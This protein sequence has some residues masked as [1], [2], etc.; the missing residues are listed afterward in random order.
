MPSSFDPRPSIDAHRNETELGFIFLRRIFKHD[1]DDEDA[2]LR[3][4]QNIEEVFSE[5]PQSLLD[6]RPP[7]RLVMPIFY[8]NKRIPVDK[9]TKC[10]E[11]LV[12]KKEYKEMA[13]K[14]CIQDKYYIKEFVNNLIYNGEKSI[15]LAELDKAIF[16]EKKTQGILFG[17]GKADPYVFNQEMSAKEKMERRKASSSSEESI[18]SD[19]D[20]SQ[21]DRIGE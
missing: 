6:K 14:F 4:Y 16:G 1:Q 15:S 13:E 21:E 12:K 20:G 10:L 11:N 19:I 5:N 7:E 3:R 8:E 18:Q 17:I 9:F 2:G